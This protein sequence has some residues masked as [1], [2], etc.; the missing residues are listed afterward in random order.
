M[1]SR[2]AIWRCRL[3]AP[4]LVGMRIRLLI[5]R[6]AVSMVFSLVRKRVGLLRKLV[7]WSIGRGR[8]MLPMRWSL[9]ASIHSVVQLGE[10]TG[11]E[12]LQRCAACSNNIFQGSFS[13]RFNCQ[14]EKHTYVLS[15]GSLLPKAHPPSSFLPKTNVLQPPQQ[16]PSLYSAYVPPPLC[17]SLLQHSES[18]P[19]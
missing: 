8:G 14:E 15:T 16:L 5:S 19:Y 6:R 11:G 10:L 1:V 3:K 17:L 7:R 13:F 9:W 2:S 12:F 18:Q 4:L